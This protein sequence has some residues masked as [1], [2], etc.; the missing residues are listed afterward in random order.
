MNCIYFM[1]R[2]LPLFLIISIIGPVPLFLLGLGWVGEG[3]ADGWMDPG[4]GP[5]NQSEEKSSGNSVVFI[6]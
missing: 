2:F 5:K 4:F 1:A 3:W 6:V